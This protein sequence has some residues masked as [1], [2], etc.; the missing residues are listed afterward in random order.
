MIGLEY[1]TVD[2]KESTVKIR[3]IGLRYNS[4][5]EFL[6]QVQY[7]A[8]DDNRTHYSS[9]GT[10]EYV[11]WLSIFVEPLKNLGRKHF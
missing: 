3:T 8:M 11:W 2:L 6:D 4:I 10:G 1:A 9:H 7:R 5:V